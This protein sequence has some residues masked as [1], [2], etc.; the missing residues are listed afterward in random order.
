LK[1][2]A[3]LNR[4]GTMAKAIRYSEVK[5]VLEGLSLDVAL[6]ILAG[7]EARAATVEEPCEYIRDAALEHT[8]GVQPVTTQSTSMA[9]ASNSY[10]SGIVAR[11]VKLLNSSGH[12]TRPIAY[13]QVRPELSKLGVAQ[14][15][16]ILTGL[17]GVARTIRDPTEYIKVAVRGASGATSPEA[18]DQEADSEESEEGE[19]ETAPVLPALVQQESRKVSN[20]ASTRKVAVRSGEKVAQVPKVSHRKDTVIEE[21]VA[22]LNEHV[23]FSAPIDWVEVGADLSRIGEDIAMQILQEVEDKGASVKDPTG[24]IKFK[25]KAKLASM[26]DSM[27]ESL[28]D[29]TKILK[30]IDWLNDYGGLLRDVDS[31]QVNA[32]LKALGLE[33]SMAI[34]DELEDQRQT[35]LDPT[36]FIKSAIFALGKGSV[37]Q[38]RPQTTAKAS[39]R[40]G[41]GA[42]HAGATGSV[43]SEAKVSTSEGLTSKPSKPKRQLGFS[44]IAGAV[45]SLG[46]RTESVLHEMQAKGLGLEAPL[47]YINTTAR[48][49]RWLV[50]K[51]EAEE[52]ED[53][54]QKLTKRLNWMNKFG[55][56]NQRIKVDEVVGMLYCLGIPQSMA[57]LKGLAGKAGKVAD[58]TSYIRAAVQ[59]ANGS[60]TAATA[61]SAV[62]AEHS[63]ADD[64]EEE[65]AANGYMDPPLAAEERPVKIQK[66]APGSVKASVA[67][68]LP[69]KAPAESIA[70]AMELAISV[71]VVLNN[72]ALEQLA[73]IPRKEA[74][75]IIREVARD[76]TA[77][78]NPVEFIR[79]EVLKLQAQ[80]GKKTWRAR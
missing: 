21:R 62:K 37:S 7:L 17:E 72:E 51:T 46:S 42:R 18:A 54:V 13:D 14:A 80:M 58:P 61:G 39:G 8:A 30:R 79:S 20:I 38:T 70:L 44:D 63:D 35:V 22:G 78:Q 56:L 36:S 2:V 40:S 55:G 67:N 25:M 48:R 29:E 9:A 3:L 53:D 64:Y 1:R 5:P 43:N 34:L 71:G 65:E 32:Q 47:Q 11:R 66:Q 10:D 50:E 74:H 12:L 27:E 59:R 19:A 75:Q 76:E 28:E 52:E 15:M 6:E 33:N 57:I 45:D 26:G 68:K 77:R 23:R 24:Y 69:A 60:R 73:S 41:Q 31:S 16:V 49:E 4:S